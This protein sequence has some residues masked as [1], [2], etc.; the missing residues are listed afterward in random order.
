M[1]DLTG[2]SLPRTAPISRYSSLITLFLFMLVLTVPAQDLLE[3]NLEAPFPYLRGEVR[4]W[5]ILHGALD[6]VADVSLTADKKE[7]EL[8][9]LVFSVSSGGQLVVDA[10]ELD[11]NTAPP[12]FTLSVSL[13]NGASQKLKIR[14]APPARP[15]SYIS[16]M[17][18]DFIRIFWDTGTRSFRK[19]EQSAFDQ[20]F[21]RLQTHGVSRLILWQSPFPQCTDPA[22]HSASDWQRYEA[23]ARAIIDNK[24]LTA[25]LASTKS[26]YPQ[27][28]GWQ[29][30]LLELRL[31]P[32]FGRMFSDSATQHGITLSASFRPFECGLTKYYQV[33]TFDNDGTWL[34]RFSPAAPPVMNY[35]T[36]KV[37]F[38]SFRTILKKMG[39]HDEAEPESI[40][41]TQVGNAQEW[42]KD[43]N[44]GKNNLR[45][46]A[47]P[48]PPIADD[49]FVL[50]RES[51]EK[52]SLKRYRDF[53]ALAEKHQVTLSGFKIEAKD[54]AVRISNLKIPEGFEFLIISRDTPSSTMIRATMGHPIVLRSRAGNQLGRVNVYRVLDSSVP[55]ASLTRTAGISSTGLYR[56]TFQA[57][58]NSIKHLGLDPAPALL[59]GVSFVVDLGPEWSIEMLD[60]QRKETR[61]M[62]VAQLKTILSYPAFDEIFVNTRSHCALAR[63]MADDFY[64]DGGVKPVENYTLRKIPYRQLGIDLGY[65]PVS[66]AENP[67]LKVLASD[68]GKIEEITNWQDRE[69]RGPCQT[70][71]SPFVWRYERN[72][73]VA[74]GVRKL[75]EDLEREFPDTRIRAVIPPSGSAIRAVQRDL[76]KM[77]KPG[78][79]D[80]EVYGADFFQRLWDTRNYIRNIGEGMA[81]VDLKGLAVEPVFLGTIGLPDDGPLDAY[82]K[83][84]IEGMAKN[85]NSKFCGPRSFI[86]EAQMTLRGKNAEEK[87]AH[88]KRRSAIMQRILLSHSEDIGEII[89]YEAA[90]WTYRLPLDQPDLYGFLVPEK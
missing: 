32:E 6:V 90:D 71:V 20:Y 48:F 34:G 59:D 14:P 70:P 37:G 16:D 18:D 51:D 10:R 45:I 54:N 26:L 47:S 58:E 7:A 72:V 22:N 36:E 1:D 38:A 68:A 61:R 4:S 3:R 89:L 9:G 55:N 31:M 41:F 23:Q 66:V 78:G 35:Q 77:P 81:M 79:K 24:D 73:A 19:I 43:F 53:S 12:S 67:R 52:Y 5:P 60:L 21:R 84:C 17:V 2:Y 83:G 56:T 63:T 50:V 65:A 82:L 76:A 42:V 44:E 30:L 13:K 40:E 85:R 11:A 27:S 62:A 87:L 74:D 75:L 25:G 49:S 69:W 57:I 28:W 15:V 29:R 33:P 64:G 46:M 39:H 88:A 86:Y 80:G 8:N